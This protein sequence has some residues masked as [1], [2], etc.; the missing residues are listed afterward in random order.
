M[1]T[2]HRST[3]NFKCGLTGDQSLT[4]VCMVKRFIARRRLVCGDKLWQESTH[5]GEIGPKCVLGP[6]F[7]QQIN[8][9]LI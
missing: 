7:P 2:G 5:V 6:V 4:G 8:L 3:V 9:P 1:I